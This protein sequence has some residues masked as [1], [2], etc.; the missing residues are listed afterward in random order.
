MFAFIQKLRTILNIKDEVIFNGK[1]KFKSVCYKTLLD[2]YV[3]N[4]YTSQQ[5]YADGKLII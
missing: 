5:I 4:W 1:H 3:K 2:Y